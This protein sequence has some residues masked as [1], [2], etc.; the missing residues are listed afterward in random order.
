MLARMLDTLDLS[1]IAYCN[2]NV[3]IKTPPLSTLK[4]SGKLLRF[5]T[6]FSVGFH[7]KALPIKLPL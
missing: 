5:I 1:V 7:C 4:E 3:L 2:A 6:R